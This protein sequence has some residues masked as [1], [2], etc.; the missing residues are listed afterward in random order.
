M[1]AEHPDKLTELQALWFTEARKY[2]GLPL[3]DLNVFEMVGRWRPSLVGDRNRF[4]Y[5]PHTAPVSMGACVMIAGRS[6]SVLAE[7]DLDGAGAQGVL[8]KQGAGHGGYVLF[9]A[10][11]R[12]QFIYNFFGESEQ[13]V[14]APDP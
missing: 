2:N 11:G 3:A 8:L 14:V 5:Y 1:A 9:V 6:F 7:V 13:R 12:L 4:V 10:D